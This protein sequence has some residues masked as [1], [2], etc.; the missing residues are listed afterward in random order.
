MKMK[1]PRIGWKEKQRPTLP[2]FRKIILFVG[3]CDLGDAMVAWKEHSL[4][5]SVLSYLLDRFDRVAPRSRNIAAAFKS[6]KIRVD[7]LFDEELTI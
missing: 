1:I 3:E 2:R 7:R 6:K 5:F 4:C